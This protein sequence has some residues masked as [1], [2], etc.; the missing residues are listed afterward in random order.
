MSEETPESSESVL[1]AS[2]AKD[3]SGATPK[4]AES[5]T[6]G[7]A[8]PATTP[9]SSASQSIAPTASSL[10]NKFAGMSKDQK[11]ATIAAEI[12]RDPSILDDP[13][14]GAVVEEYTMVRSHSGPLPPP[15]ILRD[16]EACLPGSA[17]RIISM[18]ERSQANFHALQ[19]RDLEGTFSEARIGQ[20]CGLLIGLAGTLGGVWCIVTDHALA[21]SGISL[22]SLA[23]LVAVFIKGRGTPTPS[24]DD[25]D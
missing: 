18:A 25:D 20:F 13:R 4:P 8:E 17:D 3:I 10:P 12:V 19:M 22:V 21:G 5:S 14:V 9:P 11:Q 1:P 2:P 6:T 15:E 23:S 24:N 7:S 16:Y